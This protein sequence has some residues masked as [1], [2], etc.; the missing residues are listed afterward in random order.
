MRPRPNYIV[1]IVAMLVK[2]FGCDKDRSKPAPAGPP[3]A[4]PAPEAVNSV[5]PEGGSPF[6]YPRPGD[7]RLVGY[8]GKATLYAKV[9]H[10]DYDYF[11]YHIAYDVLKV[12]GGRWTDK[13]VS[14]ICFDRW[15]APGSGIVV[16]KNP[17]PLLR[18]G[19]VYA[20]S[21]D[22]SVRPVQIVGLK[23]RSRLPPHGPIVR[24][25]VD[26]RTFEEVIDAATKFLRTRRPTNLASSHIAEET[27][28]CYV[29]ESRDRGAGG[30]EIRHV[31]IRKDTFRAEFLPSPQ[32]PK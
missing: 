16:R 13:D 11:W 17:F 31:M 10:G 8:F 23:E 9:R 18:K 27:P 5:L 1:L 32:A 3:V 20:F 4:P 6:M 21:L 29:V 26:T 30:A 15:P 25:T 28:E 22:T 14:L 12:E 24:S 7:T 19:T 2:T